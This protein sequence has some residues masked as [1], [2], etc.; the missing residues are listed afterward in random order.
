MH[1]TTT[2]MAAEHRDSKR[3][4]DRKELQQNNTV[5]D[6]PAKLDEREENFTVVEAGDP[7]QHV[8]FPT[9]CGDLNEV[10]TQSARG[11]LLLPERYDFGTNE[12]GFKRTFPEK[13]RYPALYTDMPNN[14]YLNAVNE[15]CI[16]TELQV[17]GSTP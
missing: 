7:C 9:Y 5:A 12:S 17:Y 13:V 2:N 14:V 8:D 4:V 10:A 15:C 11:G 16:N 1:A 6:D 3:S